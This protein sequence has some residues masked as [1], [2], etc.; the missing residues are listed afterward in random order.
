MEKCHF[1]LFKQIKNAFVI[2]TNDLVFT[3]N[4]GVEVKRDFTHF[5]AMSLKIVIDL[6]IM[7]GRLQ[8]GLGRDATHV[9][10]RSPRSGFI[11]ISGPCIDTS[12]GQ[13]KLSCADGGHIAAWSGTNHYYI[14]LFCHRYY[15]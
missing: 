10:A 2:L 9:G 14:K 3:A 1:I 6:V 15:S 11:L 8:Q 7:L 13:P 12:H 5:N 4:K